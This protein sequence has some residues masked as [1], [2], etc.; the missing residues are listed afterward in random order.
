MIALISR[1]QAVQRFADSGDDRRVF[2][3]LFMNGRPP[4]KVE[5][6]IEVGEP[7]GPFTEYVGE[8]VQA[9]QKRL[10]EGCQRG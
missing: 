8:G 7:D 5:V 3:V 10:Q 6:E 1:V 2:D 9:S 4:G